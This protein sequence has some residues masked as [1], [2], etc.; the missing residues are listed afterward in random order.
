MDVPPSSLDAHS[1][2]P[3]N[4]QVPYRPPVVLPNV[5][6]PVEDVIIIFGV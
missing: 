5:Q 6:Q 3:F 4:L 2:S 1:V